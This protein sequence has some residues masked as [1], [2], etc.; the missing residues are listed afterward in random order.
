MSSIK[1]LAMVSGVILFYLIAFDMGV[2]A[3]SFVLDIA[4]VRSG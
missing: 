4:P 2:V 1:N 3:V